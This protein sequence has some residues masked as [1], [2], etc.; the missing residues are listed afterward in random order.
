[1]CK[2]A[3][4]AVGRIARPNRVLLSVGYKVRTI[5][6]SADWQFVLIIFFFF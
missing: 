6:T 5:Q 3:A 1:M 2:T 4:L